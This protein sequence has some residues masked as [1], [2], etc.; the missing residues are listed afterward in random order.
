MFVPKTPQEPRS[1]R[2]APLD[3][4]DLWLANEMKLATIEGEANNMWASRTCDNY[5]NTIIQ[6]RLCCFNWILDTPFKVLQ[7]CGEVTLVGRRST[8]D[9]SSD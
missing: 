5:S 7:A 4:I 3:D 9:C 2:Y 6:R 1:V 8:R